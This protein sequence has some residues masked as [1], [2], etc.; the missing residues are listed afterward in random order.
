MTKIDGKVKDVITKLESGQ[1]KNL[2]SSLLLY[3]PINL[4]LKPSVEG[5]GRRNYNNDVFI[6][7]TKVWGRSEKFL[8]NCGSEELGRT[9]K[10][11]AQEISG[12]A[13]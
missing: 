4:T 10:E 11:E 5:D 13:A 3:A 2:S 7:D 12:F 8:Q 9:K 6:K 1:F